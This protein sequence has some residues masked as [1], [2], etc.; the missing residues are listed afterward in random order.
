MIRITHDEVGLMCYP[1]PFVKVNAKIV[2]DYS[3]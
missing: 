1:E 2:I 3:K